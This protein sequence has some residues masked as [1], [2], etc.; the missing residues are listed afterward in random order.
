[1]RKVRPPQ[2]IVEEPN[3][4]CIRWDSAGRLTFVK[5]DWGT[6]TT[7]VEV[8]VALLTNMYNGI[9]RFLF[10][11]GTTAEQ[12]TNNTKIAE[13]VLD[14][15]RKRHAIRAGLE[16]PV[17]PAT[18][19]RLNYIV[20]ECGGLMNIIHSACTMYK[21]SNPEQ[22]KAHVRNELLAYDLNATDCPQ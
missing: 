14:L 22:I 20:N 8:P 21:L 19:E 5:Y 18:Q 17:Y 4:K 2:E 15:I 16:R 3:P 12:E 10:W 11:Y 7:T 9:D 1:M 6:N 13:E